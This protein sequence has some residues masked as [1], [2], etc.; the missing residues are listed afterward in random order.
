LSLLTSVG[1]S[2]TCLCVLLWT[3]QTPNVK[4]NALFSEGT[5]LHLPAWVNS[6][7]IDIPIDPFENKLQEIE[8]ELKKFYIDTTTAP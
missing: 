5:L 2:P 1:L 3:R 6:E 8:A 4:D 7:G